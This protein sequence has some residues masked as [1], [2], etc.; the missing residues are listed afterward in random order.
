[1]L[2][3]ED[4]QSNNLPEDLRSSPRNRLLVSQKIPAQYVFTYLRAV[5]M[6]LNKLI[7][8]PKLRAPAYHQHIL[9]EKILY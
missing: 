7:K 1:M 2:E 6:L 9:I 3:D 5:D 8:C 4:F